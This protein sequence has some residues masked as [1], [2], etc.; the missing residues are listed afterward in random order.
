MFARRGTSPASPDDWIHLA[1]RYLA[2]RD[3]TV[4]QVEQFLVN[5]GASLAE[6]RQTIGRLSDLRYLN[7]RSFAERWIETRL[8]RRP[9]GRERLKMELQAKGVAE[10]VVES[11]IRKVF[12]EVD[13]EALAR[14]LL[15]SRRNRRGRLT[16]SQALRLLRQR[17][18]AEETVERMIDAGLEQGKSET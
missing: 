16:A 8:A 1:V 15:Q 3:R 14:R 17:G 5:R 6:A 11:V 2:R 18:F 7:D 9:M 13:E 10:A 12:R 4:A